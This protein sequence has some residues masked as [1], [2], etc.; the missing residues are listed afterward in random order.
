MEFESRNDTVSDCYRPECFECRA[1]NEA[2]RRKTVRGLIY[3]IYNSQKL[4][5]KKRGHNPPD[6]TKEE[7]FDWIT[8]QKVFYKLYYDWIKF[9]YDKM[10]IPSCDR[11]DDYLPYSFNNINLTTWGLNKLKS[12]FDIKN[13]IN[14]KTSKAIVQKRMDGNYIERYHSIRHA[15]RTTGIERSGISSCCNKK[16]KHSNGYI[17]EFEITPPLTTKNG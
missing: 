7:L 15:S 13:G 17:W 12:N 5:S 9:G 14:N 16:L 11:K 8:N 1:L 4:S 3:G 10:F 2:N 6:Y